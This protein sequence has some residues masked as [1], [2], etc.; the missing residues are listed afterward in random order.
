MDRIVFSIGAFVAV[1]CGIVVGGVLLSLGGL[2]ETNVPM[3]YG[4]A[5]LFAAECARRAYR[6][7]EEDWAGDAHVSKRA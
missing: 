4:L 1:F 2:I 5:A 7:G 3:T 6:L